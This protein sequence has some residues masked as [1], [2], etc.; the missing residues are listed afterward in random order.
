M[1]VLFRSLWTALLM[2][3][4]LGLGYPLA[5]TGLAQ[6]LFPGPANGSL[7]VGDG[8]TAGSE[9]IGQD[10]SKSPR[11]L[12]GRPSATGDHPYN[13]Q[14]SGG[15]N[16]SPQGKAYADR[17]AADRAAWEKRAGDAGQQT[18]VPAALLT[19]SGSGL[20]PHLDLAAALWQA[21]LIA[22]ARDVDESSV[23]AAIRRHVVSTGWPWDPAPYV[24][25]LDVNLDLDRSGPR[26]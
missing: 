10:W 15:S 24:N 18:P 23:E 4:L 2:S 11:W 21:P 5:M 26:P 3:A 25:V 16:L 12:Q 6:L 20:D 19:T 9:L 1:N 8:K 13:P 14:A 17:V 22:K 7:V